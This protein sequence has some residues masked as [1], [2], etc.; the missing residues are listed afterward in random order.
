MSI[1]YKE[2]KFMSHL[3]VMIEAMTKDNK[4]S[5]PELALMGSPR[6]TNSSSMTHLPKDYKAPVFEIIQVIDPS[7]HVI[8]VNRKALIFFFYICVF[9]HFLSI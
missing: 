6:T 7:M 3:R 8:P 9:Y 2:T 1:F 4:P 5:N